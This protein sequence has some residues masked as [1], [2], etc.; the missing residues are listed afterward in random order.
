MSSQANRQHDRPLLLWALVQN[1]FLLAL[2]LLARDGGHLF[3][4]VVGA[5]LGY[6]V[7]AMLIWMRCESAGKHEV[8]FVRWGMLVLSIVVLVTAI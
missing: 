2:T 3:R 6:W 1:I 7:I 5:S 4:S 8:F